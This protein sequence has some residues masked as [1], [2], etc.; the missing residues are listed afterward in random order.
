MK[1]HLFLLHFLYCTLLVALPYS[2]FQN[3]FQKKNFSL[4]YKNRQQTLA[5]YSTLK[6]WKVSKQLTHLTKN[7][8]SLISMLIIINNKK[9][10][11][12]L[13]N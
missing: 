3:K 6:L 5:F 2:L 13:N 7:K 8:N 1:A 4:N 10:I 9:K 12:Q 11:S